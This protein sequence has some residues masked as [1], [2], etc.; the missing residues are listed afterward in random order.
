MGY[1]VLF[2]FYYLPSFNCHTYNRLDINIDNYLKEEKDRVEFL[3]YTIV[4]FD[5]SILDYK[6]YIKILYE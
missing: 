6:D 5:K 4:L 2:S 3:I 1:Y